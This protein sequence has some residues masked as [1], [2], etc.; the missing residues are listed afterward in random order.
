MHTLALERPP[1]KLRLFFVAM[2]C[3]VIVSVF[4]GFAPTFYLR[5][6]FPQDRP[7]SVL[8]HVHGIVFSSWVSLFL[9][10]T[11][12]IARGSRRLHQRLGWL[13]AG[14]A[15]AMVILVSAAVIEQL[16]RVNGFPPPPLALALSAFDLVVF[17]GLVGTALHY[18]KR[19]DWHKRF[20]LSATI[21]LLGAPMFRVAIRFLGAADIARVSLITELSVAAFFLPCFAYD[22]LTRRRLHPAFVI[23]FA[24]IVLDQVAQSM[25]VSWPPWIEFSNALQRMVA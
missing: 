10:Q 8:L 11:L 15:T 7:M 24:L 21:V 6:S 13:G 23:G 9:I 2:A 14:I 16:R 4:A 12:L 1:L 25:V 17:A 19:P 3:A 20:M 22:L 18:R 5:G